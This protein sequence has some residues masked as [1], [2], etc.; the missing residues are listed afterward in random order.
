M[1]PRRLGPQPPS[2]PF[3]TPGVVIHKP[4]EE[5]EAVVPLQCIY[6]EKIC[7]LPDKA[8]YALFELQEVRLYVLTKQDLH[9]VV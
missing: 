9:F 3:D 6:C 1:T 2:S 5:T 4:A 8:V 7:E